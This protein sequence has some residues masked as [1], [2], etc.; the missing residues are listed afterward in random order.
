M[1]NNPWGKPKSRAGVDSCE[2]FDDIGATARRLSAAQL[3]H[4]LSRRNVALATDIPHEETIGDVPSIVYRDV[5]GGHGNFL[6]ASYRRICASADWKQRLQ[7][8]YTAGKRMARSRDRV[9]RE[10]ECANSS[11]ALLM[12]I[13]CYPGITSRRSL[14]LLLGIERGARPRFGVRTHMPCEQGLSDRT[15]V[16]M[17]LGRLLVEAKLTEG[18]FQSAARALVRR[19]HDVEQVFDTA[20]LLESNGVI[21]HYQLIRGV[22]AAHHCDR[23][24][25]LLCD[26]RRVD[27][28]EGWYRVLRAVRSCELRS[29]LALLTWQELSAALPPKLQAFLELKYGI[30]PA[31]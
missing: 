5:E 24:F 30:Y 6:S 21:H 26:S 12:N 29:R 4:E 7:K 19:Y 15:E 31:Q 3:R 23:S 8:A 11:D 18:S 14:C 22:L 13:F 2:A 16:D 10:L 9:R 17:V 27:L 28:A 1:A 25:L 20:E